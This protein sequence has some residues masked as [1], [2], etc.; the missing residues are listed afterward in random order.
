MVVWLDKKQ[1]A[2]KLNNSF[3]NILFYGLSWRSKPIEKFFIFDLSVTIDIHSFLNQ[4]S[5]VSNSIKDCFI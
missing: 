3:G 5:F 1:I 2:E 4:L